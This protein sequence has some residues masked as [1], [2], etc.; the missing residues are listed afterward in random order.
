MPRDTRAKGHEYATKTLILLTRLGYASTR[1]IARAVWYRCD[2]STRKMASRTMRRLLAA[3]LIVE[4]RDGD[5]I[6]GE[7]LAALTAAGVCWLGQHYPLPGGKAHARD[8]LRHAHSHR[9]MCNAVYAAMVGDTLDMDI[10]WTEL[11]IRNGVAP[12]QLAL[13]PYRTGDGGVEQKVPDV[14]FNHTEPPIWVEVENSWR[15]TKDLQKLV[16]FLRSVFSAQTPPVAYVW[17]VITAQGARTIGERLRAAMTHGPTS[18]YSSAVRDLDARILS[19][20]IRVYELD[21][22]D[23]QLRPITF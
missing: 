23:L 12:P 13:V 8:W 22:D 6:N 15:S 19:D 20:H 14:L 18:G 1:Q 21:A 16:A 11:E 4:R 5:S 7:R 9:T 17:L 3:G 10:G 2:A